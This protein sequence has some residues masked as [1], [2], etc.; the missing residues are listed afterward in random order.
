ML[1]GHVDTSR[2]R[3]K[4]CLCIGRWS[5]FQ[6]SVR[7]RGGGSEVAPSDISHLGWGHSPATGTLEAASYFVSVDE[8]AAEQ[9]QASDED[10]RADQSDQAGQEPGAGV[11]CLHPT[12]T[13]LSGLVTGPP[14][15]PAVDDPV[16]EQVSPDAGPGPGPELAA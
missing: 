7:L 1:R 3:E 12:A 8:S 15:S 6:I 9:H 4:D 10:T 14:R 16:A 13:S 5:V 2:S 11:S